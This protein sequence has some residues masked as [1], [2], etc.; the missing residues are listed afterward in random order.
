MVKDVLDAYVERD[1]QKA[2]KVWRRDPEVD[3]YYNQL[4][5]ELLT[6]ILE[7]PQAHRH[8][9]RPDVR[10]QEPGADRRSRHQ[11]RREGLLHRP[12][13]PAAAVRGVP[14]HEAADPGRRGRAAAAEAARLQSGGGRVR[15]G[16][17]VRRRGGDDAD[18]GAHARSACCSTG[19]CRSSRGS[20]CAVGCAGARTPRI[21]RSSCSPPAARSRTGC[22]AS[23]PVRTTSSAS[24][25]RRPS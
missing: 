7:D 15:R 16:P 1:A 9:R 6:Y 24:R 11:H 12:R 23:T 17:G 19:C 5:R 14:H 22:G 18:R 20:R 4:F 21:C 10:R 2:L 13:R 3:E 25:S 8:L